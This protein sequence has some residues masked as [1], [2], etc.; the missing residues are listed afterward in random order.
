[1]G[2]SATGEN[3][4]CSGWQ[5]YRIGTIREELRDLWTRSETL[6]TLRNLKWSSFPQCVCCEAQR[7]CRM[8]LV[9]NFNENDGYP[10]KPSIYTCQEA[11]LKKRLSERLFP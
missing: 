10:Y 5:G 6:Q 7:Y 8:C 4:P 11:F 3:Y 9:K 1:M 2:L